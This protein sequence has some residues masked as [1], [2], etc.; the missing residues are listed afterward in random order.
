MEELKTFAFLKEQIG[1]G[2]FEELIQKYILDNPH[3]AIV[4]IKPE[5]GRTARLDKELAE[6]LQEYKKSLSEAEVE[7]IVADTKRADRISGRAIDE[8][9]T[10]SNSGA[11]D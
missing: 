4:V 8:R 2:Y 10:G 6:R 7:K 1:S 3:G 5:K 9:R 11:G